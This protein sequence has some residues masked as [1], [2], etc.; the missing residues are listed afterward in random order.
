MLFKKVFQF[1][2][3]CLVSLPVE[4]MPNQLSYNTKTF[5]KFLQKKSFGYEYCAAISFRKFIQTYFSFIFFYLNFLCIFLERNI[6]TVL[7]G[8]TNGIIKNNHNLII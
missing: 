7:N 6:T 2:K 4:N 8:V 5:Y 3:I 1:A